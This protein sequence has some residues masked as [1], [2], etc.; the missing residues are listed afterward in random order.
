MIAPIAALAIAFAGLVPA[1]AVAPALPVPP[2]LPALSAAPAA[3]AESC[4]V[5]AATLTWGFKESFRSY[6]SST[7]A[8]GEWTVADGA[9][10]ATPNFGFDDGVGTF[11]G[12]DGT[13]S[14]AGSIEF[15]GHGGILDTTISK[16]R[17]KFVDD[18]A[19]LV[20]DVSGTTQQGLAVDTANVEFALLDLNSAT[21]TRDATSIT[22]ANAP[23]ALTAA[24]ADA[25]GT[26]PVGEALDP[27][28]FAF[29]TSAACAASLVPLSSIFTQQ[30]LTTWLLIATLLAAMIA[31]FVI[32]LRRELLRRRERRETP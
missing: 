19:L 10:Y 16:P 25:F 3:A 29:G 1:L 17:L 20:L 27:V 6:I 11:V 18:T 22:V 12:A 2:V 8:N 14:F 21:I 5:D 23:A 4:D 26:Y 13:V 32:L 30:P 9:T 31:V 28:T 7:I 15:T 24:G